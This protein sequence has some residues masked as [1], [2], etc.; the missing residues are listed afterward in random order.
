M[1]MVVANTIENTRLRATIYIYRLYLIVLKVKNDLF[2][3]FSGNLEN[4]K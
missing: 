1:I 3:C 2:F 4:V